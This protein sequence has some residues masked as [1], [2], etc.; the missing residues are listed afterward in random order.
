MSGPVLRR[1]E[2]R[3][4]KHGARTV[5]SRTAFLGQLKKAVPRGGRQ[6]YLR[7]NVPKRICI[8]FCPRFRRPNQ[9]HWKLTILLGKV[10][11]CGELIGEQSY[12]LVARSR[13]DVRCLA[14]DK[15]SSSR[16]VSVRATKKQLANRQ[17]PA[18]QLFTFPCYNTD[19]FCRLRFETFDTQAGTVSQ[20][21]HVCWKCRVSFARFVKQ[22]VAWSWLQNNICQT[23]LEL[24]GVVWLP[25]R[26][27]E[28]MT[29]YMNDLFA[30]GS[31][32]EMPAA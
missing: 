16:E 8:Y 10:Q 11:A 13:L 17:K 22:S 19:P 7:K 6:S 31:Q 4:L 1:K 20:R 30:I 15:F 24:P 29:Q 3:W 23:E 2:E 32:D 5:W 28:S 12:D 14:L 27:T 26:A 18:K 21:M 9:N 25:F